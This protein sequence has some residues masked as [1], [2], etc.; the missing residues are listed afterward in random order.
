MTTKKAY[1]LWGVYDEDNELIR[2]FHIKSCAEAFCLSNWTIK[3]LQAKEVKT[4]FEKV[5]EAP[6]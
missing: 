4:P 1:E 3:Q 2:T 5:G 6:F